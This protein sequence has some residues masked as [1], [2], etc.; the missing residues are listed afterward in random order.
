MGNRCLVRQAVLG[1]GMRY[2]AILLLSLGLTACA[3]QSKVKQVFWPPTP[4]LPRIQFLK[5]IKDSNDVSGSK[6]LSLV[7]VG[8]SSGDDFVP[9]VKPYGIAVGNGKIY[10]CDTVQADVLI[11]DLPGKKMT[12]LP[13][14]INA[15]RLK[16][17]INVASDGKGNIYVTDTSRLE[18]LKYAP[19]G[20]YLRSFGTG[21]DMKPVD[22]RVDEMYVYILDSSSSQILVFDINTG[23][24]LKSFGSGDDPLR[25]LL[26]PTNMATDG[27]GA[28]FASN[29]GNGRIV[30]FD[31]DGN[32][33]MGYGKLGTTVGQFGRPR[34]IAVD[35]EGFVYVVDAAAQHVQI[36]DENFR[37]MMFFGAP[38]TPGSLNIPAGI[39]V[40]T[41]NL[42]YYQKL[43]APGFILEKVLFVV[44]QVGDHMISIYGVG[45]MQGVDYEADVK[46]TLAEQA[47]RAEEARE[48]R[49]KAQEEKE[50]AEKGIDQA[51]DSGT[52]GPGASPVK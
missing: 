34:G 38:G 49:L 23:E 10:V 9:I 27:K 16:K 52:P 33:L 35:N 51:P 43:A 25:R 1:K 12:R 8:G 20:S 13:G 17:P 40:S 50:K 36:F 14:N 30:K 42:D 32:F 29:F 3:G 24:F 28:L 4:D 22:V 5:S 21:K 26:G 41:D 11:I 46:K 31:R 45:K 37:I 47:K 6:S 19:D 2:I 48:K 7:S 18:V 44:S 15:G 39:A